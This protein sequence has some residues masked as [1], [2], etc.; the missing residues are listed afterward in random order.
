[1][2]KM[3]KKKVMLPATEVDLTAVKYDQ[4]Q[5]EGN[6]NVHVAVFYCLY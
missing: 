3:G 1:M 2:Q 4:G 6:F 5:I